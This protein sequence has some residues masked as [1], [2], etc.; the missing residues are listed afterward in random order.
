MRK[1]FFVSAVALAAG[2]IASV[3]S[4]DVAFFAG[5]FTQFFAFGRTF[6]KAHLFLGWALV[7]CALLASPLR[8]RIRGVGRW[9]MAAVLSGQLVNLIAHVIY[10]QRTGTAFGAWTILYSKKHSDNSL[11]HLHVGKGSLALFLQL[12]G[13]DPTRI[14][15]D[16][17]SPYL[18]IL[19]PGLVLVQLLVVVAAVVLTGAAIV[20][21]REAWL[22]RK[23]S[24]HWA[25]AIIAGY[26]VVKSLFDGGPFCTEFLVFFPTFV[27]LLRTTNVR[28]IGLARGMS[29]GWLVAILLIGG[30]RGLFGIAAPWYLVHQLF[31]EVLFVLVLL[32]TVEFL[33]LRR[34]SPS[35]KHLVWSLPLL[36]ALSWNFFWSGTFRYLRTPIPAGTPFFV[37][38]WKSD[39]PLRPLA[40]EG[41]LTLYRGI[42]S[43][44]ST[45][46]D[47]H[48][49]Y[50]LPPSFFLV[51][52][53]EPGRCS[54]EEGFVREG[55]VKILARHA[56][57]FE[58]AAKRIFRSFDTERCGEKESCDLRFRAVIEG[59]VPD[60]RY[61]TV[62]AR[63]K[64]M[65]FDTFA[66]EA[67]EF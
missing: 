63:L 64:T 18:A 34:A 55:T 1:P 13:V 53:P 66:V 52:V 33:A 37:T 65:G 30:L 29:P 38:T 67:D 58:P 10:V 50:R 21:K 56:T 62:L 15:G 9:A 23:Y 36:V 57:S 3:L 28:P 14:V 7:L 11:V 4:Y 39:L 48:K 49:E 25:G 47:V 42:F 60:D 31:L 20:S 40:T 54:F 22:D 8:V 45:I 44:A 41:G 43:A 32:Q 61:E 35:W 59:C 24:P 2:L 12:I 46:R 26:A 5:I 6:F 51:A 16:T 19:P 27:V 17:G